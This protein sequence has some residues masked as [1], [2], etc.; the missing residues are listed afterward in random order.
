MLQFHVLHNISLF[1]ESLRTEAAGEGFQVCV[2]EHVSSEL[3]GSAQLLFAHFAGDQVQVY[4]MSKFLVL[5]QSFASRV[6]LLT[7]SF[8][9]N[10]LQFPIVHLHMILQ[11]VFVVE[12]FSTLG[13]EVLVVG[14]LLVDVPQVL[15]QILSQEELFVADAAG[16][17]EI[18]FGAMFLPHVAVQLTP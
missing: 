17:V 8:L 5:F 18:S 12:L 11:I 14:S 3:E 1:F 16:D 10:M 7:I 13:T 15:Y 9:A 4:F 6:G 2:D